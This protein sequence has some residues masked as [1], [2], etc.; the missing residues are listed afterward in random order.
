MWTSFSQRKTHIYAYESHDS[1]GNT[2]IKV[3][4]N[5]HFAARFPPIC[6]ALFFLEYSHQ[7]TSLFPGDTHIK[8]GVY[9]RPDTLMLGFP[10]REN[11][12]SLWNTH[13]NA[14][15]LVC[16]WV[17][18]SSGWCVRRLLCMSIRGER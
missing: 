12:Y 17:G 2:H 4:M 5:K 6:I 7:G 14:Y 16:L 15:R 3:G 10:Q 13:V 8:V 11:Y 1:H 18:M 9:K